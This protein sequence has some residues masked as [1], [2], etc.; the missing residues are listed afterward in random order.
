MVVSNGKTES[1]VV[2]TVVGIERT[3]IGDVSV[4][5]VPSLYLNHLKL[6]AILR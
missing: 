6:Y 5:N 4:L 2:A 1:V 3:A